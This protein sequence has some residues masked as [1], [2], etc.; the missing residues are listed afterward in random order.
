MRKETILII[1]WMERGGTQR[2]M[3]WQS[4]DDIGRY[5]DGDPPEVEAKLTAIF[6]R[7]PFLGRQPSEYSEWGG[8]EVGGGASGDEGFEAQQ[9]GEG[10]GAH[11]PS[12]DEGFG[13]PLAGGGQIWDL[14]APLAGSGGQ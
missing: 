8:R 2:R 11:Q 6:R 9:V 3:R 4:S 1:F 12:D 13:A 14:G 5:F 10:F 7:R